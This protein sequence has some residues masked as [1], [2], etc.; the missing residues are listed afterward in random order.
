MKSNRGAGSPLT[1]ERILRAAVRL[2][3]RH[4]IEALSMRA[5]GRQLG[6]QAMS[7]YNHVA[8]KDDLL[9]SVVDLVVGE[10]PLPDRDVGWREAM[11]SRAM[12]ARQVFARHPWA[13]GLIDSR[14]SGSPGRL[15]WNETVPPVANQIL[16]PDLR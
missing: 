13:P 14:V 2:A 8:G 1:R 15:R 5:L 9:D 6:R 4:G 3:D 10:I 11:R 16:A 12:A 7:L